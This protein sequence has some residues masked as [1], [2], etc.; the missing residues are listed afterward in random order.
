MEDIAAWGLD[1]HSE[2]LYYLL[3]KL[4][5]LRKGSAYSTFDKAIFSH[6]YSLFFTL[7][8]PSKEWGVIDKF[9]H[10]PVH[11]QTK[12]QKLDIYIPLHT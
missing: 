3:V 9:T 5:N 12:E 8:T 11:T 4:W 7:K 10:V 6:Y 1:A 2:T